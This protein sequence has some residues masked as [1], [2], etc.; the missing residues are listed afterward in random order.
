MKQK[1]SIGA[2][3]PAANKHYFKVPEDIFTSGLTKYEM[4][5]CVYLL[6]LQNGKRFEFPG[7]EDIAKH[8]AIS[9]RKAK[10][11]VNGLMEKDIIRKQ[12]GT[13]AYRKNHSSSYVIDLND[14]H[15]VKQ[16]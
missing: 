5:V 12:I 4:L 14:K 3:K 11:V 8:C 1:V 2:K 10:R 9:R 6:H 13:Q 7:Y 15:H 16:L